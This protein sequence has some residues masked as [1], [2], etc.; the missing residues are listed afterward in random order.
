MHWPAG[1]LPA[2]GR[3]AALLVLVEFLL[4]LSEE[5]QRPAVRC[6]K[7]RRRRLAFLVKCE[8]DDGCVLDESVLLVSRWMA[9]PARRA[10][11]VGPLSQDMGPPEL[12]GPT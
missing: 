6:A 12:E 3:P 7:Q 10:K 8:L 2:T 5:A 11:G 4:R 9:K 1:E